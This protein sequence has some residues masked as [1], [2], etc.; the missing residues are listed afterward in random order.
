MLKA[1]RIWGSETRRQTH[2]E[3]HMGRGGRGK[4]ENGKGKSHNPDANCWALGCYLE[5]MR[6][7]TRGT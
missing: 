7:V 5:T 1:A 4:K 6:T 2:R 3:G